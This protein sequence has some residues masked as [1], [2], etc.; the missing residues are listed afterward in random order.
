MIEEARE[1]GFSLQASGSPRFKQGSD[2]LVRACLLSHLRPA[3]AGDELLKQLWPSPLPRKAD[4][5]DVHQY[6][7]G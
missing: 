2:H 1:L 7:V 6:F 5:A 4:S 3:D